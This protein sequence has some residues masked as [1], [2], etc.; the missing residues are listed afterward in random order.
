V[1]RLLEGTQ[2]KASGVGGSGTLK[3]SVLSLFFFCLSFP[4]LHLLHL[5]FSFY[6]L[7]PKRS[8]HLCH[9]IWQVGK[10]VDLPFA[11]AVTRKFVRQPFLQTTN[12]VKIVPSMPLYPNHSLPLCRECIFFQV[13]FVLARWSVS[14]HKK[15]TGR[16]IRFTV[17]TGIYPST[18]LS[19]YGSRLFGP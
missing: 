8:S 6:Q 13:A 11:D 15:C 2:Y 17:P 9:G 4:F 14:S 5:S 1:D 10:S 7:F 18:F 12:S 19:S 3:F 16:Y